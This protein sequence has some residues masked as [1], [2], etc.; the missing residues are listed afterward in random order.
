MRLFQVAAGQPLD[1]EAV[2]ERVPALASEVSPLVCVPAVDS[3]LESPHARSAAAHRHSRPGKMF[4]YL[5]FTAVTRPSVLTLNNPLGRRSA[6]EL[7]LEIGATPSDA[8]GSTI[9]SN[10]SF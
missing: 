2:C 8:R 5:D 4:G 6:S 10:M 7:H 1:L 3:P 9:A